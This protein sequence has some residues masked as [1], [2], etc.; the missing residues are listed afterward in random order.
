MNED[1]TT[2]AGIGSDH[3]SNAALGVKEEAKD[4]TFLYSLVLAD[5]IFQTDKGGVG[6]QRC[7]L[8]SK[9][10]VPTFPAARLAQLQNSA[11]LQVK[12]QVGD[13]SFVAL[14]VMLLNIQD[15]G[16]MSDIGFWGSK[17]AV[18]G[19]EKPAEPQEPTNKAGDSDN[20]VTIRRP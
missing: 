13:K 1:N 10:D 9:S 20:V 16:Y 3:T 4:P 12:E 7:Q 19:P 18:P 2:S 5:V 14:E 17:A 15:L 11:A 8:F 6:S